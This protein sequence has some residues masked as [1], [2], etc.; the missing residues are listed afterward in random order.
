MEVLFETQKKLIRNLNSDFKRNLQFTLPW[1]ERAI[2]L[3]G[4][5]GSGKTTLFLQHI[6]EN[7]SGNE[8]LYV[9]LDEI[10][11]AHV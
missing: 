7:Y 1:D 5:R 4:S 3:F 9:T 6:K 10:G 8:A 11:R 2:M